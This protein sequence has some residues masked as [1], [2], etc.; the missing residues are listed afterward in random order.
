[1][2]TTILHTVNPGDAVRCWAIYRICLF[3]D[4]LLNS[5]L[6]CR[7]RYRPVSSACIPSRSAESPRPLSCPQ[8]VF[9]ASSDRKMNVTAMGSVIINE[10][11]HHRVVCVTAIRPLSLCSAQCNPDVHL[12]KGLNMIGEGENG[13]SQRRSAMH[14]ET[15]GFMN[16]S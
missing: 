3:H 9:S 14:S 1:M 2:C 5:V 15:K 4:V 7:C 13:G 8:P 10:M 11:W 12:I 6:L 16:L